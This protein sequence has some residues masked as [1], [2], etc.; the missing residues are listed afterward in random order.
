[1]NF[2][3]ILTYAPFGVA[4]LAAAFYLAGSRFRSRGQA[5]TI[6]VVL[7]AASKFVCFQAFGGDAFNPELPAPVLMAFNWLYSSIFVSL[8]LSLVTLPL[9]RWRARRWLL[10]V[11]AAAVAG[12]GVFCG[13]RTPDVVRLELAVSDLPAELDGYRI[14]QL[15]DLHIS[16]AARRSRTLAVVDRANAERADLVCVTGDI[17]DGVAARHRED[18]EPLAGLRAKDGVWFVTGNHEF[19]QDSFGWMGLYRSLGLRF[20]D[21]ECVRPHPG[22]ALAGVEGDPVFRDGYDPEA[23]RRLYASAEPGDFRVLLAHFPKGAEKVVGAA[24]VRLQLSGHTHGGIMPLADRL[25]ALFNGG[26]VHGLYELGGGFLYVSRGSGQ[27]AGFPI[28]LLNPSE[29][30]VFTLRRK[31]SCETK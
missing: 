18:V 23:V 15:S 2:R 22:L 27:W 28:R 20:L 6:M 14:L 8:P 9:R 31:A 13:V 19:Y 1:M 3:T 4:A 5:V 25:I 17:A 16:A 26:F 12:W 10:P 29:I 11:L 30:T 21:G 24:G 7:L